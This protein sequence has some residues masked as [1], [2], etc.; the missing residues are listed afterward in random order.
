M[1]APRVILGI[2]TREKQVGK[3]ISDGDD[4]LVSKGFLPSVWT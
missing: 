1:C 4:R 3:E 2:E